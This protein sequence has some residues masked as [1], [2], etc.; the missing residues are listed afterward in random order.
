MQKRKNK[1][2]F[3]SIF[4]IAVLFCAIA[5]VINAEDAFVPKTSITM[6]DSL[7]FNIYLPKT[8]NLSSVTLDGEEKEISSLTVKDGYYHIKVPLDARDADRQILLSVTLTENNSV[9]KGTFTF[10][11]AKYVSRLLNGNESEITKKLA[12]DILAYIASANTFFNEEPSA[13]VLALLQGYE[14]EFSPIPAENSYKGLTAASFVLGAKPSVRFYL[15]NGYES[16]DFKFFVNGNEKVFKTGT[17]GN[18]NYMEISLYAY[19][20]LETF[21]Y[22]IDGVEGVGT[23]NLSSYCEYVNTEY[24]KEDKELLYDLAKKFYIYC[25]SAKAYRREVLISLCDHEYTSS[26]KVKATATERGIMEYVCEKCTHTYEE[27]IPTTLKILAI[28]NSFSEDAYKHL[29]IVAKDAGIENI[30]LGNMYIGGCSLA[31]HM[32]NMNGDLGKY[33]FWLSSDDT[34]G[35]IVEGTERTAKYGITYTDW[36]YITIQQASTSSGVPGTYSD[37]QGIVDYINAN[38]TAD[39]EILWHMTWAYQKTSTHSG[40][41]NYNND[42]MTMY[43]SIIS[44]VKSQILTNSDISGVIPTGTAIQNLRTS[45]LGDT[46]TRDGYHLSEGIG[47]YTASLTWIA[48]LTGC[49]VNKI[50]ITPSAYPEVAESLDYIK[51]AVKKAIAK[52]Y[53]ITESAYPAPETPET[54]ETPANDKLLN[55]TLSPLTDSDKEYLE[56]NGFDPER[57]MLLDLETIYNAY[58][59]STHSSKYAVYEI[60]TS[61]SNSQYMK[62]WTTQIFTRNELI[63]GSIIRI[64]EGYK[65]RPEAWIDMAKNA[66]SARPDVVSEDCIV[67]N[68]DWW[69]NFNYRA[70]NVGK[71]DG[72]KFTQAEFDTY[73]ADTSTLNFKIYI[74]IVKR[75]ELNADDIA[76]LESEGLNPNNYLVLDFTYVVDA[77]Y[78]STVSSISN[79]TAGSGNVKG[80]FVGTEIFSK[81]DLKLGTVIRIA[82]DHHKYRPE[83][84]ITLSTKNSSSTRPGEVTA[85]KV[86]VDADWWGDF[87]YRGFNIKDTTASYSNPDTYVTAE[88]AAALRIYVPK[89]ANK[90]GLTADDIAYLKSLGLNPDEYKLLELEFSHNSY[91]DSKTGFNQKHDSSTSSNYNKFLATQMFTKEQLTTGSIIRLN[92]GYK[93]RPEGWIDLN[94]LNSTRPGNVTVDSNKTENTVIIDESWWGNYNYRAF[95]L[96]KTSGEIEVE[97]GENLRIYIK[98][99]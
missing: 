2:L 60:A 66:S 47:R 14:A 45:V 26:V 84:F 88:D 10:S 40:F 81:Y 74:P 22:T 71:A 90:N 75:A 31:T 4:L 17:D 35:M 8:E 19:E 55:T 38:K 18:G 91:Y 34:Q 94:T 78:N 80:L 12:Q 9:K 6:S 61:S 57:Y 29:Y 63:S 1:S 20:M 72:T 37:L 44:T 62:W 11:I 21:T 79:L 5:L 27:A 76:Y 97:E 67:I 89:D 64:D 68:D 3:L 25:E 56:S 13:D 98:I 70:F 73:A 83:G 51:D 39:A 54:P 49:D 93:Y 87:N 28:G 77:F 7:V 92:K 16:T 46:L 82:G 42:Q 59:N 32:T 99:A 24:S 95:N 85:K 36:D 50:S 65:Y 48:Y 58:Y 96:G 43:N 15:A 53:E 33:K 41:A 30:V 86:I 52:P 69:G 23:Y